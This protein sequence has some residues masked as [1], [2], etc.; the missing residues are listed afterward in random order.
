MR[1]FLT[2]MIAVVCAGS[3]SADHI[4]LYRDPAG[5]YCALQSPPVGPPPFALY[6]IHR[7][8]AGASGSQFRVLDTTGFFATTQSTIGP[9]LGTWNT[10]WSISYGGCLIGDLQIATLNFL[11]FGTPLLCTNWMGIHPAPTSAIVGEIIYANCAQ[12]FETATGGR[13]WFGPAS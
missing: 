13:I 9:T 8:N 10:D 6:V 7:F 3:A 1:K 11:Y 12:E 4:G 5:Q 2:V